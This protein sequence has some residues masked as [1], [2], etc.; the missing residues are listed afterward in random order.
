MKPEA[1]LKEFFEKG[2]P[3]SFQYGGAPVSAESFG[4]LTFVGECEGS[5]LYTRT[6]KSE[7]GN[8]EAVLKVRRFESA[9][10]WWIEVTGCGDFDSEKING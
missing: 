1:F 2:V 6:M 9:V 7:E 4:P 10:E 3:F 8:L 5:K